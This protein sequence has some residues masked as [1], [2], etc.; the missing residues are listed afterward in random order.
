MTITK[1]SCAIDLRQDFVSEITSVLMPLIDGHSDHICLIDPP[2]YAN[3]GD[4]AILLGELKFLNQHFPKSRLSF[5]DIENYSAACD[6]Y[7]A[8]SSIILL[9]GGGNFGDLWPRHH[10]FRLNILRKFPDKRIIQLPQSISLTNPENIRKTAEAI[11]SHSDFHLVVRDR[12]SFGFAKAN[13]LC[14]THICPDMAFYTEL[15]TRSAATLDCFSLLR[16]DKE[17]AADHDGIKSV[18]S[19]LFPHSSAC[20]DW[21]AKSNTILGRF[22]ER[23]TRYSSDHPQTM[24]ALMTVVVKAR[25]AYAQQRLNFGVT[26]L[27]RGNVIVT[28]RLHAHILCCIL[29][30]DHFVF[31]SVDQK[32]SA[33]YRTWTYRSPN[34]C[35]V[36]SSQE[37]YCKLKQ[38]VN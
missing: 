17:V 24:W 31:D 30:I 2:G 6:G 10:E 23:L 18:V 11:A 21:V 37:L 32:V 9:Q 25:Q 29:G 8:K 5:F 20:G 38:F 16:R 22:D 4:S 36:E 12:T 3:V 14:E 1:A 27:C 26:M 7:I 15:G 34:A 35:F 13:F 28:D 33:M 19:R